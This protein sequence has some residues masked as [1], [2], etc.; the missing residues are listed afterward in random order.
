MKQGHHEER[1]RAGDHGV[2]RG[3]K[4]E[5][6]VEIV[7]EESPVRGHQANGMA[8][9]AA[10]NAQGQFRVFMYELER[11][12]VKRVEVE[13]HAGRLMDMQAATVIS[14]GCNDD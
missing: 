5:T 3:G 2:E 13:H 7:M 11:W 4:R 14:K 1:Q 8:E 10:Q 9:N 12:I 6:S